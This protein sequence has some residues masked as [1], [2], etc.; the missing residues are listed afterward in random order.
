MLLVHG[1][2]RAER[3]SDYW[4]PDSI[5]LLHEGKRYGNFKRQRYDGDGR[6]SWCVFRSI[7]RVGYLLGPADTVLVALAAD[8]LIGCTPNHP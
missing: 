2:V 6:N 3:P 1:L 8:S 5:M 4:V 7:K